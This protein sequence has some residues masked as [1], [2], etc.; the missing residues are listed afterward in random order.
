MKKITPMLFG[1]VLITIFTIGCT[2]SSESQIKFNTQARERFDTIKQEIPELDSIECY[3]DDCTSVIYFN[4]NTVPTDLEMVIR[5]NTGTF[6]KFKLDNRGVSHVTIF[7]THNGRT[8]YQCD[9]TK[10]AVKEC[11]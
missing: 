7:A 4:F 2:G 8:I 6:S 3:N 10:G 5:G 11:R 1:L 9:G